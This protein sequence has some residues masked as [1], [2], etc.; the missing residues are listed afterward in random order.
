MFKLVTDIRRRYR[1]GLLAIAILISTSAALIQTL[2]YVQKGDAKV[3]NIA[4]KQRML[5]Q[6]IALYGNAL[7][8]HEADSFQQQHRRL[9]EQAVD[10]FIAGHQF[11]IQ[12]DSEGDYI[13]LNESLQAHYFLPPTA[14][15]AHVK[16]YISKAQLLLN[17]RENYLEIDSSLFASNQL[18]ALLTKLDQAVKLLEQKSVHKVTLLA[19]LEMMFWVIAM[20]LLLIELLFVFKPMEN[21]ITKALTS[22]KE[23]KDYAEQVNKTRE[24]FIAR[25]SHEFRTPL[26]GLTASIESLDIKEEQKLAQQ[27]ALYCANRLVVMLDELLDLQEMTTGQWQPKLDQGNLLET[28][29]QAIAPYEYAC[30]EKKITLSVSLSDSLNSDFITDHPRLQQVVAELINNAVKFTPVQGRIAI[31]AT[32]QGKQ[33]LLLEVQDNGKGFDELPSDIQDNENRTEQHFQG[34]KTGLLRVKH[35]VKALNGDIQFFNA[36]PQGAK[37]VINLNF[38]SSPGIEQSAKLPGALNCLIVEDNPLN[39][40]I[41]GRILKH[42][43]YSFD[44]AENG[45]IATDMA[46]HTQYD[47]IFMD[48]NMPVMDGFKAIDIIR[49]EQGQQTPIL[50]VTANTSN[51][52]LQRVYE[53]GANLHVYKPISADSVEKALSI[54]FTE[55]SQG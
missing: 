24:R 18:E 44:V 23:Q 28:L 35:I 54:L 33:R 13:Y 29:K 36:Q 37:V 38:V 12:Q 55:S 53:L 6:K 51:D 32:N 5:S 3:I 27:Q 10:Q 17:S 47:V 15:D 14:L 20:V 48:L 49:N 25:T 16:R 8:Y 26:Q 43:N 4:G 2:L 19:V 50:V 11:L 9:L 7:I 45:L 52:D 40:T 22:Y 30:H 39:A 1:F 34:L 31:T 21:L 46:L 41:L 42:F